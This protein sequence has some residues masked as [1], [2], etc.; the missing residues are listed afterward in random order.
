MASSPSDPTGTASE[1][2]GSVALR[3]KGTTANKTG[4]GA[5]VTLRTG[6]VA[7][8]RELSGG[9]GHMTQQN[10]TTLFFGL[11]SCTTIDEIEVRWPTNP[12]E[13]QVL[14]NVKPGK[15]LEIEQGK[16]AV[17]VLVP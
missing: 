8:V 15:L 10:D 3:L 13:V 12:S 5:K 11:A 6:G 2:G 9:Y 7:Q 4:I 1:V 17:T 16:S 14:K